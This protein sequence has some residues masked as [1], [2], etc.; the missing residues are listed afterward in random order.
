[1]SAPVP[2]THHEILELVAP[3]SRRGRRV[4]LAASDRIARRLRFKPVE[5]PAQAPLAWP[6][7]EEME[8]ES[9]GADDHR[10]TRRLRTPEG[11]E[12]VLVADGPAVE[13]LVERVHAVPPARQF[14]QGPGWIAALAHR[15]RRLGNGVESIILTDAQAR[16][17]GLNVKMKV[18]SVSGV[19]ADLELMPAPGRALALPD[20]LLAVLGWPWTCIARLREGW[21]GALRLKGDGSERSADAESKF[22]RTLE[23]LAHTLAAPPQVFHQRMHRERWRVTLR[24]AVPLLVSIA[25]I[26]GAAMVPMIQLAQNSVWRMLVFHSPAFLLMLFF[27]LGEMPR[28]EFPPLPRLARA[29]SWE[30]VTPADPA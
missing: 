3:F 9:F 7:Q 20:D 28:L 1:M 23:H 14:R 15:A 6:L 16:V 19:N 13:E 10:V 30:P 29:G 8:L 24:R 25:L 26:A 2:L 27:C 12:A 5:H 17:A 22:Q 4:D 11:L 18:S 21:G